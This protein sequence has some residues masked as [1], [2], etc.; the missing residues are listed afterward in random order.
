MFPTAP[1]LAEGFRVLN[2]KMKQCFKPS[3][4]VLCFAG[5]SISE[6]FT[7]SEQLDVSTCFL[8]DGGCV[9][10]HRQ[11]SKRAAGPRRKKDDEG[12][13]PV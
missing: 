2:P 8:R 13:F 4:L 3:K 10:L 9:V 6:S 12:R 1:R 5:A 11:T 7:R